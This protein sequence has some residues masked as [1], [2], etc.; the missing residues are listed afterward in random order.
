MTKNLFKKYDI[1]SLISGKGTSKKDLKIIAKKLNI[2]V[3]IIWLKD[4]NKN[5]NSPQILNLGNDIIGGSH[6]IAVYDNK[7]FDS[8]GFPPPPGLTHLEYIP[9]QIQ[10]MDSKYCGQFCLLW[11]Y[12]IIKNEQDQF[13]NLFERK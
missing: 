12:Y 6:W 11:L 10:D 2:P 8:F 3:K 9:F 7:Y 5:D 4:Y 13:Y 1:N